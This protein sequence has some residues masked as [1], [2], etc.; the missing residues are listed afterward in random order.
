MKEKPILFSG[1]MV[2]AL[3]EGRKTVTR[4]VAK[5]LYVVPCKD[6][7]SDVPAF[8]PGCGLLAKGGKRYRARLNP[9]GAVS[10]EVGAEYLGLKPGEFDFV[11]PY[12]DGRT[13][14]L[15][16][17]G[18]D[19][20]GVFPEDEARLWV[21]ETWG[22]WPHMGGGV[23]TGTVRYRA[24]D[25]PPEDPHQAWR[26]R[27]SIHMPREL[28]RLSLRVTDVTLERLWGMDDSDA[29]KEGVQVLPLQNEDDPSAWWMVEPGVCAERTPLES[30]K[31]L[32][33]GINKKRG[34]GWDTNPW[35]WTVA[36]ERCGAKLDG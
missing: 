22:A 18:E 2:R 8:S 10:A 14:L 11:C 12:C 4:R 7:R 29:Q 6:V 27:P 21:R 3:L 32:W 16:R 34:H 19:G 25:E 31:M 13:A 15:G 35:V 17:H 23:Q 26:W 24:T 5:N 28:S 36:F 20:W 30:F 9:H 1:A 33:D